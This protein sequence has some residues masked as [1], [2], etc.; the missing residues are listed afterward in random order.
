MKRIHTLSIAVLAIAAAGFAA[1]GL[2]SQAFAEGPKTRIGAGGLG[3]NPGERLQMLADKLEMSPEQRAQAKEIVDDARRAAGNALLDDNMNWEQRRERMRQ[4]RTETKER[5]R[6]IL[7]PAQIEKLDSIK[8][9]V[10]ER[11]RQRIGRP[12]ADV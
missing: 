8:Q 3:H 6:Q 4:I 1:Q 9:S 10:R 11:I 7:T 2:S 5:M 12:A